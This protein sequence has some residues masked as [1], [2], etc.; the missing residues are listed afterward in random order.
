[1]LSCGFMGS[2]K[3]TKGSVETGRLLVV[4]FERKWTVKTAKNVDK[5]TWTSL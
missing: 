5:K 2:Y 3:Y 1:M 4:K